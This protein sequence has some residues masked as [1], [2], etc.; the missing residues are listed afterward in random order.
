MLSSSY[1]FNCACKS[2]FATAEI[3]WQRKEQGDAYF[4]VH[5]PHGHLHSTRNHYHRWK[6]VHYLRLLDPEIPP[7]TCL[8]PSGQPRSRRFSC[9][10]YR[11][12]CHRNGK[13]SRYWT[14][15]A[16]GVLWQSRSNPSAAF[17]MLFSNSSVYFLAL[18][19]LERAFAVLWPIRHRITNSRVYIYSIV[20]VWVVGLVFFGFIVL[21]FHLSAVKGEYV[22]VASRICLLISILII[23]ASYLSIRT[24][25]RATSS[26]TV[27]IHKQ[28][29]R[30][31]NLRLAKTLYITIA[32]SLVFWMPGFV[33]YSTRGFCLSCFST[34]QVFWLVDAM[35]MAN[36]MVNPLVYS[37]RMQIFKDALNKFRRKRR[38]NVRPVGQNSMGFC[39]EGSFT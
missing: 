15:Y 27:D 3:N 25:L 31:H 22:F 28:G 7:N 17:F 32:S 18:V 33:V 9:G 21:S 36:S 26:A 5:Y 2:C 8:F 38:Q 13:I 19:S 12:Y 20:I 1:L 6:C 16:G 30:E 4:N 14:G 24:R 23:C 34:P 29:S 11:T 10:D 35:Y 37:F 39:L